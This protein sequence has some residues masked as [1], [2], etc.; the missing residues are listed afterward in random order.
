MNVQ[1]YQVLLCE[2]CVRG[3]GEC[4]EPGCALWAREL[5]PQLGNEFSVIPLTL[6]QVAALEAGRD[7]ERGLLR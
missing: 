4:S 2:R 1:W 3:A 6:Q 7:F 5:I